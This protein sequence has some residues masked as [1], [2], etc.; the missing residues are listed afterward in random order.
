MVIDC[1]TD[2]PAVSD[3]ALTP[4]C[5]AIAQELELSM[6]TTVVEGLAVPLPWLS[7]FQLTVTLPFGATG[8]GVKLMDFGIKSGTAAIGVCTVKGPATWISLPAVVDV[9]PDVP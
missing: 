9:C 5:E 2:W 1:E 6:R 3:G 7:R 4:L 8:S